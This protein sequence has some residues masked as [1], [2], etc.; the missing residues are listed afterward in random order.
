MKTTSNNENNFD[1]LVLYGILQK[2]K[3]P[4]NGLFQGVLRGT[5]LGTRTLD[6]LIKSQRRV[7]LIDLV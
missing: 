2:V 4:R 3:T 7:F 5:P 6:T 1:S